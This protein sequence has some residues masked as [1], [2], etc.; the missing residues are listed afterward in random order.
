LKTNKKET[1]GKFMVEEKIH[2]NLCFGKEE[3]SVAV[4]SGNT[5]DSCQFG[6][7]MEPSLDVRV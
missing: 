5:S 6:Q 2:C 7:N 1:I 4:V 3:F